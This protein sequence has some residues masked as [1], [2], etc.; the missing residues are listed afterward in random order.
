MTIRPLIAALAFVSIAA[1]LAA[2]A[3][4]GS[5]SIDKVFAVD[6]SIKT[7]KPQFDRKDYLNNIEGAYPFV[8][9]TASNTRTREEVRKELATMPAERVGA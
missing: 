9:A 1:P 8:S 4:E 3:D 2:Q 5:V 7:T 6:Q